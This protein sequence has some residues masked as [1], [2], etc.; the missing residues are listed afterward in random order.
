VQVSN[1]F[2]QSFDARK[3]IASIF[4]TLRNINFFGVYL[5]KDYG[6]IASKKKLV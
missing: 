3:G 6:R 2:K 4:K 5:Y 1:V